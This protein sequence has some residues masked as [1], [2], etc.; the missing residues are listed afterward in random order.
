MPAQFPASKRKDVRSE[1]SLSASDSRSRRAPLV[2]IT[3]RCATER[4]YVE[5]Y[6][7]DVCARGIFLRTAA[8]MPIGT[9]VRFEVL[10]RGGRCALGGVGRVVWSREAHEDVSGRAGFGIAF[11]RLRRGDRAFIE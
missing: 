6:A 8:P 10:L 4:E 5:Q 2:R 1:T 3:S 9:R 11:E 7:A